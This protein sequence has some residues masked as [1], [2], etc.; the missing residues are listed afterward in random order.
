[1]GQFI[2]RNHLNSGTL[3]PSRNFIVGT[4]C[5]VSLTP[6]ALLRF[7]LSHIMNAPSMAATKHPQAPKEAMVMSAGSYLGESWSR[8]T[9]LA[10]RPIKFAKGT[11]T[12]V[13]VTRSPS[14]ATLLLYQ[15]LN[16]TDG[17]AVP[18]HIMKV[19]K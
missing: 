1:M 12:D 11:P 16:S 4:S 9:L 7:L 10:T 5:A 14:C 18:Q 8:K 3:G 6:C 19:A 13:S 2:Y 15:V 17:A